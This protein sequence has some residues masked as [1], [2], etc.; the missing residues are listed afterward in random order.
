M[1]IIG[2]LIPICR[3]SVEPW[4]PHLNGQRGGFVDAAMNNSSESHYLKL[5]LSIFFVGFQVQFFVQL[6]HYS[7]H[8]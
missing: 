4:F 7:I 3:I 5:V 8:T 1:L 6:H 2:M